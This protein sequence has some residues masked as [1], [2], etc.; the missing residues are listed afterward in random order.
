MWRKI[1]IYGTCVKRMRRNQGGSNDRRIF[2]DRWKGQEIIKKIDE[3]G[4]RRREEKSS[5]ANL[6]K[7]N[8]KKKEEK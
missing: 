2:K 8:E 4:E 1:R 3:A 7:R 5:E 6:N